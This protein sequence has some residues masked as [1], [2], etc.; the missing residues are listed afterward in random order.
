MKMDMKH[1]LP[2]IGICICHEAETA[3]GN[4][5]LS[6]Y[7]CGNSMKMADKSVIFR[8]KSKGIYD[9]FPR[10]QQQMQRR[11]G[12]QILDDHKLIILIYRFG[13]YLS[14]GDPAKNA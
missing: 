5:A 3:L 7:C 9:M 14:G 12:I 11:S 2:G 10:D 1:G 4:P 8:E 6:G 13:G